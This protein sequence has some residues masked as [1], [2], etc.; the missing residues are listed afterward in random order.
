MFYTVNHTMHSAHTVKSGSPLE[1]RIS[2]VF[3]GKRVVIKVGSERH[4]VFHSASAARDF[5]TL[6]QL[7]GRQS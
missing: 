6:L 3:K 5:L 7:D 2:Q 1:T 4:S